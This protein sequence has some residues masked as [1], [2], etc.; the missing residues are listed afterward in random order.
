AIDAHTDW[1]SVP[2]FPMGGSYGNMRDFPLKAAALA[3]PIERQE[4]ST[5]EGEP[6]ADITVRAGDRPQLTLWLR[7]AAIAGQLQCYF[8]GEP[9][10]ISVEHTRVSVQSGQPLQP[11]RTR[12]NCTARDHESGRYYW[13][14]QPWLVQDEKGRW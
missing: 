1:H 13:F 3:L 11:G 2:R 7:D 4:R 12:Y 10:D 8:L 14:S 6:L 5:A 9:M